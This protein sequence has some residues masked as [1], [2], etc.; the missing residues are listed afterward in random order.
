MGVRLE[1]QPERTVVVDRI[2]SKKVPVEVDIKGKEAS[3]YQ[4]QPTL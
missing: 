4:V 1:K 2:T 3:G